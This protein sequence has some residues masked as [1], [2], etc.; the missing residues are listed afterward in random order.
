MAK[1]PN[2]IAENENIRKEKALSKTGGNHG[3]SLFCVSIDVGWNNRESGKAHNS[4]Y[5]HHITVGSRSGL[6]EGLQYIYKRCIKCGSEVKMSK[7]RLQDKS[8]C[9]WKYEESSKGMED[10]GALQSCLLFLHQNH[11]VVYRC[12]SMDDDR[13]YSLVG[14]RC[15]SSHQVD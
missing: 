10:Y 14:C 3:R 9:S 4:N 6:V 1:S 12:V 2:V 7:G 15:S 5:G 13:K 8:V 11:D